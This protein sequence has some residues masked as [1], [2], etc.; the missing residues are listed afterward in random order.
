[1]CETKAFA[2]IVTVGQHIAF[3]RPLSLAAISYLFGNF[4]LYIDFVFF[5][6]AF[7]LPAGDPYSMT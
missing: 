3:S 4:S 2:Y 1:M 6:T 7:L 5:M